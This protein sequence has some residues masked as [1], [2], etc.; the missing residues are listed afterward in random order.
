MSLLGLVA[1]MAIL[2]P[3]QGEC[4]VLVHGLGRT[5]ASMTP[6]AT[7]LAGQ[8]Y[9]VVNQGYPSTRQTIE[10]SAQQ[11]DRAVARCRAQ[12]AR[13]IHFVT[14]SLGGLLLRRYLED[15]AI[16]E[17]GRVV[18]LAPP[19]RGSEIADRLKDR[20]WFR[21]V[22]GPAGQS[23]MTG[24]SAPAPLP[25]EVGIIAGTRNYEP[26]FA[27]YFDGPND[28]KVTVESTRLPG[29]A[30]FV[31]IH[32][33]HTFMLRSPGVKTQ[34]AAFLGTGRFRRD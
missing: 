1:S 23:L 18:M 33:G 21:R 24:A 9:G 20:W 22:I 13:R 10:V 34:V 4:V 11:I 15:H 31:T 7:S 26:W 29:M 14:H 8:G 17:G 28:G 30:D 27:R 6:L 5:P 16:A 3:D 32:A 25:L 19:N 2:G 12:G